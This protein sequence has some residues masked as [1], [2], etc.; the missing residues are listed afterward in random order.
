MADFAYAALPWVLIGVAL[1]IVMALHDQK[2]SSG[3]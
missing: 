2:R 3:H 1:A